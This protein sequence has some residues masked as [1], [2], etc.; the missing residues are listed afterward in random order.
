M[1]QS[2]T[3]TVP[4]LVRFLRMKGANAMLLQVDKTS[5]T[6]VKV[7]PSLKTARFT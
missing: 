2:F 6:R 1:S 4:N 7:E 3:K 5:V